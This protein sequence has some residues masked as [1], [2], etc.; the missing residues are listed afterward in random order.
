MKTIL[1]VLLVFFVS[2]AV[3]AS[4]LETRVYTESGTANLIVELP[5]SFVLIASDISIP[6]IL[7][8]EEHLRLVRS[9]GSW[10]VSKI[11]D[12]QFSSLSLTVSTTYNVHYANIDGDRIKDLVLQGTGTSGAIDTLVVTG[13][14]LSLIHI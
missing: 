12:E 11:S 9:N 3:E 2:L 8:A 6:L 14:G 5:D 7:P 13:L 10:Q 4:N 1:S